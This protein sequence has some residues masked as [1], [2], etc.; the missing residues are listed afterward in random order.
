MDRQKIAAVII[1]LVVIGVGLLIFFVNRG[2]QSATAT[3]TPQATTQAAANAT[4]TPAGASQAN[5]A[6]T[7]RFTSDGFSPA[8]LTVA[9]GTTVTIVNDSGDTVSFASN[10][11]PT[12][13]DHPFLNLGE[14]APG[15]SK[16]VKITAAGTLGYHDHL[17]PSM[18][19]TIVAQ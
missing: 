12:H 1:V 14:I 19:G 10:P 11:H 4:A 5:T 18:T 6:A 15:Q 3:P 16:T 9:V 2:S 8:T 17:D 13:T 7:I